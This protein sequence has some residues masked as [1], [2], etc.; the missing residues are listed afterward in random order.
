MSDPTEFTVVIPAHNEEAVIGRC[1]ATLQQ[2]APQGHSTQ[3]IVAANG[4]TDRTVEAAREAAPHALVLDLPEGSKPKAMNAANAEALYY[5]RIYLDA[6]VQCDY[7]SLSALAAALREPGAMAASPMLRMDL[8]RSSPLV[9]SYYRVWLTQPYVTRNMV[10][11]GCFGLSRA[12]CERIGPFP[13]ITGD[14]IWVYSR[15]SEDERR[16]VTHD[17]SGEPVFFTVSPPISASDQIRVETRR[18]LGNE[19]MKRLYPS[20]HYSSSNSAG[21]L[22][23]ALENGASRFD[24]GVYLVMKALARARASIAKRRSEKIVWERDTAAREA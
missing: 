1:L 23:K 6:D 16:S 21:D 20:P 10:G 12:A 2:R 9:K 24:V 4:C 8:S 14:D 15:F 17:A 5:P 22:P 11:S 19:E 3:V 18:R 7:H 13:P